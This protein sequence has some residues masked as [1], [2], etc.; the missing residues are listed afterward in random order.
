MQW[1]ESVINNAWNKSYM[2]NSSDRRC[3]EVGESSQLKEQPKPLKKNLTW[4][5]KT[6]AFLPSGRVHKVNVLLSIREFIS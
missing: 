3:M 4:R 5:K 1:S 2:W 6:T